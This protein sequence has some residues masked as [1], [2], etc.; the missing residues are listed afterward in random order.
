MKFLAEAE[1]LWG[2]APDIEITLE[3]NP[4][5]VETAKFAGLAA[6]GVNR[7]SM[8]FQAMN[9]VDLRRLGRIHTV[10]E[11]RRA[12]DIARTT[13]DRVSFDLIY[14]RQD[15]GKM[16]VNRSFDGNRLSV[17]NRRYAQG[18][19]THA[20]SDIQYQLPDNAE[21]FSFMVALD[22]EVGTAD[23]QFSVWGDGK[24]LWQSAPIYG[25][26][27]HIPTHKLNIQGVKILNLKV[28]PLKDDK[29]DHANWVNTVITFVTESETPTQDATLPA[30]ASSSA[31]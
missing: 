7:V 31:D 30:A 1:R 26:E 8:G 13:F 15:H 16:A 21:T 5:S 28:A 29:W 25:Y 18:I 22:D 3:A 24:L 11:A 19:G 9:D 6:A 4:S 23:V 27:R 2:F 20:S 12:F 17:A 14:A 10:A